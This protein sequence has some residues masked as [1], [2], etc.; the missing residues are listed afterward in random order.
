[1]EKFSVIL[2]TIWKGEYVI[3][4][5]QKFYSCDAVLEVILINNDKNNTPI[6]LPR[7]DKL[8]HVEL[9][10][11]IFVNPAWNMGVRLAKSNN[12]II[13]SDDIMFDLNLYI[14]ILYNMA[15]NRPFEKY[16]II[17]IDFDNYSLE[18]DNQ[19]IQVVQHQAKMAWACLLAFHKK[20]WPVI[21]ET[22][23]IYFGDDFLKMGNYPILDI[24]G[25]MVKTKMSTTADTSVDWVKAVT[26]NDRIEW[27]KLLTEWYEK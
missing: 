23:K 22:I 15:K 6:N 4:L 2:P 24:S 10:N 9:N 12:I 19:E 13:A 1:M 3:Q 25:L 14:S 5:L 16:G 20:V 18:K 26:D 27:Q 21:P 7:H 17:G 11:N 8:I